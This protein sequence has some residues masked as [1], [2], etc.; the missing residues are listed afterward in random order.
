VRD[1]A[2]SVT[3]CLA[4]HYKRTQAVPAKQRLGYVWGCKQS[5]QNE[6]THAVTRISANLALEVS[7]LYAQVMLSL[8]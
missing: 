2:C 3:G 8:A 5:V 4:F 7:T 1:K 6:H